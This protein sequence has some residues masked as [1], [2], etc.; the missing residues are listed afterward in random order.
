M[1]NVL[2][3]V[4]LYMGGYW[5]IWVLLRRRVFSRAIL[6]DIGIQDELRRQQEHD[7]GLKTWLTG[8]LIAYKKDARQSNNY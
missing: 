1:V 7:H 8:R 5:V 3:T 2:N 4:Y 6:V